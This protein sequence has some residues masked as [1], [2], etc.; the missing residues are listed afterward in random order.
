MIPPVSGGAGHADPRAPRAPFDAA[1]LAELAERLAPPEDGAVVGFL[2]RTRVD[3]RA[4]R[5]R[6]RRPRPRATPA[7]AV[8]SLEYEAHESM[9]SA[10][11]A[12]SPTRS[13]RAS[14]S[15]G[16]RSSIGP[17]RCRSARRR[18]RSWP[19]RRTG[20][21]RSTRPATRSTRRR[22]GRPIWKAERFADGHVWI[23]HQARTG[24][25]DGRDEGLHQR[26]HG[27]HR[28][29]QPSAPDRDGPPALSGR[30]R[31]HDRRDERGDRGRA[32]GRRRPTSSSTTATDRC[33]TCCRRGSTR[34]PAPPGPE[35]VVDGRRG[36]TAAPAFDVALFVGYHARA[37]HPRG[38]IAHTYS[39][40]PVETR[41]DGRP[42]G[43]YGLNALALGAW[44]SRSAWSPATTRWPRRS[45]PGCRGPSGSWSRPRPAVTPRPRSTRRSP[46]TSSRAGAERAVRRAAA[47][48]L[49]L[50]RVG[51]PVVIEVDYRRAVEA[52]HAAIVPGAERVGDR[53]VRYTAD[54]PIDAYR[55]FLAGNRLAGSVDR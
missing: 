4:R 48:E 2:G 22:R 39:G 26:R 44:G 25:A 30:G 42:T 15:T 29:R 8:E 24:P 43:E 6:A 37:G 41:L 35:A 3:A 20:T 32:G 54:D 7:G 28:R 53:G 23:G 16:W 31:A 5:R 38:T 1:I 46:R 49:E 45:R 51:P 47:G 14:G 10:S 11:S 13:R 18:S 12:R 21:R 9:A 36:G 40:A 55:G 50:L 33:T 52:D 17:A 34:R 19:S 27:G